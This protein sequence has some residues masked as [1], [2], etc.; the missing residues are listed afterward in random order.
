MRPLS[1][2]L[3]LSMALCC[4]MYTVQ[5]EPREANCDFSSGCNFNFEPVCGTDGNTYPNECLL[6]IV[7]KGRDV[8]VLI[9]KSGKC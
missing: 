8:D 4:F 6:C 3:L 9:K 1:I 7:N 2:F 5:A